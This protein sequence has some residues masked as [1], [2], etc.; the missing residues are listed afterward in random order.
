MPTMNPLSLGFLGGFRISKGSRGEI[1]I[2][3]K[4]AQA[5]LAYLALNAEQPHRRDKLATL[6]W[7]DR[8]DEQARHSLRQSLSALRKA[9]GDA[10]SAVMFTERDAVAWQGEAVEVDVHAF[11]R[12]A[13]R[14][15]PE[16][17]KQAAAFYRGSLLE[18]FSTGSEEFDDWLASERSRLNELAGQVLE[19]LSRHHDESG[20]VKPAIEASKRL[21]ALDSAREDAHRALMRHYARAGRRS[22]ALKQYQTCV[23]A[24]RR[25][26]DAEPESET[27][28]L[29]D[30]IRTRRK[31]TGEI[32]GDPTATEAAAEQPPPIPD[33][34]SIAV[35]PFANLSADPRQAFLAD[36][37]VED[38]LTSLSKISSMTVIARYST[39][40]Y[41][42]KAVDVRN[43]AR[44]LG[45]RY[46]ME[47]SVRQG[48]NRL[49]ITAQLIDS[50]DGSQLWAESYDR[51]V[52]D[53]FDIQDEI[54]KEIVTALRVNLT[55]SE[56]ALL[57]NRGTKNVEAWSHCV[58][59]LEQITNFNPAENSKA[60]ELAEQAAILDPD[61]AMAWALLGFTYWVGAR[62]A[63]DEDATSGM[64]RAAELAEK[65]L[66]LDATNSWALG[67]SMQV[68]LSLG[69]FDQSLATGKRLILLYPGSADSRA[70]YAFALLS[71]GQPQ[72]SISMVK[73]AMRLNPRHPF[74]FQIILARALDGA[75]QPQEALEVMDAILAQQ[76]DYFPLIMLRTGFLAREGREKEAKE[77]M[78]DLRRI[79]PNFRLARV[80]GYFMMQDQEYVAAFTEAL[81]KAGLPE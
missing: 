77:A 9:L 21:L 56:Q 17:L 57:L 61:Y 26:L 6:L 11:E 14:E 81:R 51:V 30:E 4:K 20:E 23:Q 32:G 47:G 40:T 34:P 52:E 45:V 35:L 27:T 79:N 39:F 78:T 49:R 63:F 43:V 72:E 48:G 50:T 54:T 8:L 68:Q 64:A 25:E 36:G 55:N 70:W 16:S 65:A 18:G 3:G 28:H 2:P 22:A 75:G 62:I 24:L 59:A 42:G 60:R 29:Y 80:K 38:I 13:A 7:G 66:A 5:L 12:L 33:K 71:S 58:Q 31:E 46:V 10:E 73:D 1:A 37:L 15:T 53:I 67:L 69:N 76:P 74:W 44:D 19:R 41:K